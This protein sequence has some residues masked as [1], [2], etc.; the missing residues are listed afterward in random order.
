MKAIQGLLRAHGITIAVDG[1]FGTSTR[2][3]VKAFQAA[4]GLPATG[5]RPG[6]DLGE[7]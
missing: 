3:A 5:R 4:N 7:A 1:I 2:D 6:H